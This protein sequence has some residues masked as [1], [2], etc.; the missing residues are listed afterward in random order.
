MIRMMMRRRYIADRL[1]RHGLADD[2]HHRLAE[3]AVGAIFRRLDHE[4]VVVEGDEHHVLIGAVDLIDQIDVLRERVHL[5]ARPRQ[6]RRK[7][8]IAGRQRE[9]RLQPHGINLH[10]YVVDSHGHL[11]RAPHQ[12]SPR[13]LVGPAIGVSGEQRLERR[14]AK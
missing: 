3:P 8:R 5:I 10:R 12:A 14:V 11:A 9:P 7:G 4:H 13:L 6:F 2:A 1:A